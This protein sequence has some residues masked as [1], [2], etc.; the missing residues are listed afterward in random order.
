MVSEVKIYDGEGN[1]KVVFSS[2]VV[3]KLNDAK[4]GEHFGPKYYKSRKKYL[5]SPTN[6]DDVLKIS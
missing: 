5:K 2:Q 4:L 6:P 1:L 3:I